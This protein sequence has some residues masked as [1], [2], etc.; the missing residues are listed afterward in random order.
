MENKQFDQFW[1]IK[2][3]KCHEI[4]DIEVIMN[5]LEISDVE[6]KMEE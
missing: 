4:I 6:I 3:P 1:R 2:C 5:K